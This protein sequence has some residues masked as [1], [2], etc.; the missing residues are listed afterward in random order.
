MWSELYP[1]PKPVFKE[2]RLPV[3]KIGI[4]LFIRLKLCKRLNVD[5]TVFNETFKDLEA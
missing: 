5:W 4:C 2:T 1:I 3:F